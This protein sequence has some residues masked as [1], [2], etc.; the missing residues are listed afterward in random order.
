MAAPGGEPACKTVGVARLLAVCEASVT[1]QHRGNLVPVVKTR[2][3]RIDTSGAKM[4]ELPAPLCQKRRFLLTCSRQRL[5][6][7]AGVLAFLV[8]R[9]DRRSVTGSSNGASRWRAR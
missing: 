5:A 3:E 4:L 7:L 8:L 6:S 2:G 1:L 9:Q